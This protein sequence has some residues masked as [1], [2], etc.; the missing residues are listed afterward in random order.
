MKTRWSE[1]NDR[2]KEVLGTGILFPFAIEHP[3]QDINIS[4]KDTCL[5]CRLDKS[6]STIIVVVTCM[7]IVS[8][9]RLGDGHDSRSKRSSSCFK[10]EGEYCT[11]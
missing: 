1:H 10:G 4:I 11:V 5:R 8:I 9:D 3:R 2:E 6:S 7:K